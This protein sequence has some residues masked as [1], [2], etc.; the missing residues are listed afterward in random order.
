MAGDEEEESAA[1]DAMLN[2]SGPVDDWCCM[3]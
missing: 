1:I 2:N 3:S